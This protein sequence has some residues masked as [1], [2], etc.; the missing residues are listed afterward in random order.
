MKQ[1]LLALGARPDLEVRGYGCT[2]IAGPDELASVTIRIHVLQPIEKAT[3]AAGPQSATSV[4]AH[5]ETVELPPKHDPLGQ[6]ADCELIAQ[7]KREVLPL[8]AAR[9]VDFSASCEPRQL[10]PG[11]TR[12]KAQVLIADQARSGQAHSG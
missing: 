4:P 1:I 8:F 3:A 9:N 11:S 2:R 7:V 5:W 12:L 6:A 10:V